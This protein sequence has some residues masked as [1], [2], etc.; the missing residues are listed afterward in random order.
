MGPLVDM[1]Y[2]LIG[3][4]IY[5]VG[6]ED[7]SEVVHAKDVYHYI[8]TLFYVIFP[9]ILLQTKNTPEDI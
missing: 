3:K 4:G 5:F 2:M 1:L 8:S 9:R 7:Q 6:L